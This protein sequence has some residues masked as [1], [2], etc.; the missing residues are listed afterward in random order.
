MM[1]SVF[2]I[3]LKTSID[4][5]R[6]VAAMLD[7]LGLDFEFSDAVDGRI[8]GETA[9]VQV[10]D[11][12]ANERW[13][14]RPLSRSEIGCYMSH[15]QIWERVKRLNA[16][17]VI[18]EDDANVDT[19]LPDFL[20]G[21]SDYNISDAVLKIDGVRDNNAASDTCSIV[22]RQVW[23]ERQIGARTTGYVVGPKAAARLLDYQDRF[24]RPIDMDL[25]HYWEHG[26]PIFTVGPALV[27]ETRLNRD[28][29]SIEASRLAVKSTNHIVRG[30]KNLMYQTRYRWAYFTSPPH[31]SSFLPKQDTVP[32]A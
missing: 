22:D 14:K 8:L 10:Y 6:R 32:Y 11:K 28:L 19:A 24:F 3:S 29:G 20:K 31:G 9:T 1:F 16:P 2:V 18:L 5:R 17:A 26:V 23:R 13:F 21:L 15:L 12:T 25:K 4:R 7:A 27:R 30:W